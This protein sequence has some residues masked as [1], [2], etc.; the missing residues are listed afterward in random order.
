MKE[1]DDDR[2]DAY[3][4]IIC[5]DNSIRPL[6]KNHSTWM[7]RYRPQTIPQCVLPNALEARI[8]RL[9]GKG[10]MPH[11]LLVGPPGVGKTTV[12]L[13][14]GKELGWHTLLVNAAIHASMTS[15]R[16]EISDFVTDPSIYHQH[17]CVLFDE[18]DRMQAN[19]QVATH[20]WL[21]NYDGRCTFIF[22]TN[23]PEK[24]GA[25][26]KSRSLTLDFNYDVE[27]ARTEMR[28]GFRIR[29]REILAAE[30]VECDE[31]VLD[32]V[33]DECWPDFR[34]MLNVL[35]SEVG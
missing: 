34:Q 31:D 2:L 23:F 20:G 12:A 17:R 5:A 10:T 11:L 24:I 8:R 32:A 15:M 30:Q 13:A 29:L 9:I 18:A 4:S 35:Q 28:K 33:L 25:P 1:D 3:T 19:A 27:P 14:I 22:C 7:E 16:S 26:V 6:P 21:E